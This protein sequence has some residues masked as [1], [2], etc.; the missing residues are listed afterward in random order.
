MLISTE[1]EEDNPCEADVQ[2]IR[3]QWLPYFFWL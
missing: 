3:Y 1:E 2:C